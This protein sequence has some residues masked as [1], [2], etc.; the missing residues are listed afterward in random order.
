MDNLDGAPDKT[1]KLPSEVFRRFRR[2]K[3]VVVSGCVGFVQGCSGWPSEAR[4]RVPASGT[5]LLNVL[6]IDDSPRECQ[7]CLRE[8]CMLYTP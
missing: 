8:T 1:A 2:L 6:K 7:E 5:G 4:P 3:G